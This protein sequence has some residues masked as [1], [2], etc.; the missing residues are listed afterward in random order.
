MELALMEADE[1]CW[2]YS[3]AEVAAEVAVCPET[4][5]RAAREKLIPAK[6]WGKGRKS[7]FRFNRESVEALREIYPSR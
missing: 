4:V 7:A 1:Q 5:R 3:V 2:P 6:R